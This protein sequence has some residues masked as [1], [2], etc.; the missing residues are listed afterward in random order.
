MNGINNKHDDLDATFSIRNGK[1][2]KKKK[3]NCKGVSSQAIYSRLPI[4]LCSLLLE[5]QWIRC[6]TAETETLKSN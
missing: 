5:C 6:M 2:K 4:H 1:K 3:Q